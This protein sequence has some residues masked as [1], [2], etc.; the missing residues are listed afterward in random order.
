[1]PVVDRMTLQYCR[2]MRPDSRSA[3]TSRVVQNNNMAAGSRNWTAAQRPVSVE[4]SVRLDENT[5]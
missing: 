4:C 2:W 5:P 3:C 1:M